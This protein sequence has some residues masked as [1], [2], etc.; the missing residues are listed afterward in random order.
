MIALEIYAQTGYLKISL[1]EKQPSKEE[2]RWFANRY[3]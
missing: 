1:A 2:F 3:S